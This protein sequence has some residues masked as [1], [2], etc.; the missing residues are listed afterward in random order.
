MLWIDEGDSNFESAADCN[1]RNLKIQKDARLQW[2]SFIETEA[3]HLVV[4]LASTPYPPIGE[5]PAD[6]ISSGADYS[7]TAGGNVPT[8]WL[9][10]VQSQAGQ[11][12]EDTTLQDFKDFFE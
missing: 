11:F 7:V 6:L 4:P 1:Q 10:D 9:F 8:D 2:K 12:F 3:K 5:V